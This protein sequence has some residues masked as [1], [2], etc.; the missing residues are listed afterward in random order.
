MPRN[1]KMRK[2][3]IYDKLIFLKHYLNYIL[4]ASYRK[5]HGIHSPFIYDFAVNVLFEKKYHEEYSFFK[6]LRK[7]LE[8]SKIKLEVNEIGSGSKKFKGKTRGISDMVKISSVNEKTGRLLFRLASYYKPQCI[9]ELG[10]SVGLSTVYL[11]NGS[12]ESTIYTIEGDNSLCTYTKSFFKI[13]DVN[14]VEVIEGLFDDKLKTVVPLLQGF[15]LIFI[16]GNHSFA[17]TLRYFNYLS[18]NLEEYI[19]IFDDICW[20]VDMRN[21]WKNVVVQ[22]KKDIAIDLF[23]M[24]IIIRKKGITPGFYRIRF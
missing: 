13:K 21:A 7:E 10:T 11:A 18:E 2:N 14:N 17:P 22:S 8:N 24:G 4:K 20:S 9:L 6:D 3:R 12:K 23:R 5:G 19:L 15:P 16:D 1:L